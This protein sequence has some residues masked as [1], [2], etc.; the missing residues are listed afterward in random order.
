MPEKERAGI[1][2]LSWGLEKVKELTG[3]HIDT[4]DYDAVMILAARVKRAEKT[5]HSE[6]YL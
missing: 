2:Q 4:G 6:R 3:G 1:S 5:G